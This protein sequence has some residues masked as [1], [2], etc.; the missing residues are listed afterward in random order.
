[1]QLLKRNLAYYWRTN[2]A[3]VA[4]VAT[5][6]AVLAGALLVGD[7]VRASLRD[8]FLQ[9]L[10][11]TDHVVTATGFFRAQLAA[12]IQSSPQFA[13]S[14]FSSAAPLIAL[15]GTITHE[16]SGRRGLNV[17]VYGIDERF[18]T[19][20][21]LKNH[22]PVNR[23]IL[24]GDAL[25]RELGSGA[26]DALLLRVEKPSEI[27]VESL[28]SR[29]EDLG[30]TLRLTTREVLSTEALGEFSVQPQ[31][32]A[33][34]AVFVPLKL[35]QR[36]L[37]Q[38]GKANLILIGEAV[39]DQREPKTELLGR[40]VDEVATIDDFGIKLRLVPEE[41]S[42]S[43]E[44]DS[45]LVNDQLAAT[46]DVAAKKASLRSFPVLSYLA[47]RIAS[48][49]SSIPYSLVTALDEE[50][51]ERLKQGKASTP[52]L[53]V[54]EANRNADGEKQRKEHITEPSFVSA[55]SPIVLNDWAARD[56]GVRPGDLITIDYYYWREN[57]ELETRTAQF[58]LASIVAIAGMAADKDL[59]PDYPGITSSPSLSDWDPPFPIDLGL[60]RPQDEDYWKQYRT[61]PKAFIPLAKG[62]E[63]WQSR[64]G[65]LTSIRIV[66]PSGPEIRRV[67][68]VFGAALRGAMSAESMGFRIIPARRQGLEAS[69]GATNFGEYFL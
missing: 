15:E 34:R 26:G 32:S 52:E 61:T 8:L 22:G 10:G 28:H 56:L 68:D 27:P 20:H 40:I 47:N 65:R 5:A 54:G 24:V 66:S 29:K 39:R 53:N 19:F 25:A 21:G 59:V 60:V 43:L 44:S 50:T 11:N 18:W 2:L 33:V 63:L 7:S 3:V 41:S 31:Q 37:E 6:V 12:D 46:A 35:L 67:L 69:R 49:H 58:R 64:F 36:E 13:S 55:L 38:E 23:E 1:M 51:F 57:G 42:I 45:K 48:S 30:R 9:R 4:G 62:Q 16:A 14:G 17:R